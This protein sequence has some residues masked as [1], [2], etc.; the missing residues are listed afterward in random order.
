MMDAGPDPFTSQQRSGLAATVILGIKTGEKMLKAGITTAR[1]LGG[2]EYGELALRDAFAAGT[3]PG[4]RLLC[5]GKLIT[6][7][8]GHGWNA[9]IEADGA[10]EVRKA[11][12]KTSSAG[13]TA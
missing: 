11:A 4:P 12:A 5:A 9:G 2:F 1:D 10:T 8:G 13:L 7:T 6:M 3:L